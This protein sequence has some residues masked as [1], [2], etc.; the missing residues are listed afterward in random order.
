MGA[1][2]PEAW[3]ALC[4]RAGRLARLG[5]G[6]VPVKTGDKHPTAPDF[7]G[8]KSPFPSYADWHAFAEDNPRYRNLAA[9]LPEGVVGVDIDAYKD[10][11]RE[12]YEQVKDWLVPT[13]VISARFAMDPEPHPLHVYD[14]MSGIYL[15]R[16]DLAEGGMPGVD[17][18]WNG[19]RYA[20]APGSVH[21]GKPEEGMPPGR[22]YQALDQR[23]GEY[24]DG[25]VPVS[26]LPVMPAA[27]R[28]HL[29]A[30]ARAKRPSNPSTGPMGTELDP[31]QPCRYNDRMLDQFR[32]IDW[33]GEADSRHAELIRITNSVI[34][35]QG[36]GHRGLFPTL[37]AMLAIWSQH[38][39]QRVDEFER[40][41]GTSYPALGAFD[42]CDPTVDPFG[43]GNREPL[44]SS[45]LPPAAGD[46]NGDGGS[47]G[48]AGDGDGDV[49]IWD[50][51]PW[52]RWCHDVGLAFGLS[53]Y[54]LMGAVLGHFA[55]ELAPQVKVAS[56][57]GGLGTCLNLYVLLVGEPGASKSLSNSTVTH[58]W[59]WTAEPHRLGSGEGL[60]AGYVHRIPDPNP[61][62]PKGAKVI[63][64]HHYRLYAYTDEYAQLM[65]AASR[66]G[67]T[68]K[69]EMRSAWSGARIGSDY[70]DI[71]KRRP[72]KEDGY[73]L[74]LVVGIQPELMRDVVKG[75]KVGDLQRY[76]GFDADDAEGRSQ[77]PEVPPEGRIPAIP[78][79]PPMSLLGEAVNDPALQ[80][81]V[82]R[83]MIPIAEEVRIAVWRG[84]LQPKTLLGEHD[85]QQRL[86][87]AGHLALMEG[88]TAV[89][90]D[91]WRVAGRIVSRCRRLRDVVLAGLQEEADHGARAAGRREAIKEEGRVDAH[92]TRIAKVIATKVAKDG[93]I[94]RKK[95]KD[96]PRS[97]DSKDWQP[98]LDHAINLGWVV[99]EIAAADA[100]GKKG[101]AYSK[102]PSWVF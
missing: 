34:K 89:S 42:P 75:G 98:A 45:T 68:L 73:R 80:S 33:S 49:P 43:L 44:S 25:L 20:M 10:G 91:D 101:R 85:N 12:S 35:G 90:P 9:R 82:G 96:I 65:E 23:T 22:I 81:S 1:P 40:A 14:G 3:E 29:T 100:V 19:H 86:R 17:I 95:I 8:G 55:A 97:T 39:P 92:L 26:D 60:S 13:V 47:G 72:V 58:S 94:L 87:V 67:S 102:G 5:Y 36:E 37:K 18:I 54:A 88:R 56:P 74:G 71:E 21:P 16:S 93:P 78:I 61:E 46:L 50:E 76:L 79:T 57:V 7:Q 4:D 24:I 6:P 41:V 62:A 31:S 64:Q 27:L 28:Q 99:E 83:V 69:A 52:L 66:G 15:Y 77:W 38:L 63:E 53:R 51:R 84:H 48:A 30:Q 59:P 11:G 70:A 2:E 32:A